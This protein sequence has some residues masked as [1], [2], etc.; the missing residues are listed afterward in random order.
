MVVKVVD[1]GIA[2]LRES[3]MHTL[4]GMV[5]GTPAYMS[6]EQASGMRSDEL[7]ARSDI[8]SL[9]VVVYEMLTGRRPFIPT[10]RWDYLRKHMMEE[11]PP[12]S[13]VKPASACPPSRT[14]G[15]EGAEERAGGTI[16][17]GVG[18]RPRLRGSHRTCHIRGRGGSRTA[19]TLSRDD[20]A[21]PECDQTTTTVQGRRSRR[22]FAAGTGWLVSLIS[23]SYA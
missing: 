13:A 3:A 2:K 19:P 10:R 23:H 18:I 15:D 4:T 8:Y 7:D 6:Y 12:F 21:A 11:P 5:L 16:P 22:C 1:F 20:L 9:G 14:R 17:F